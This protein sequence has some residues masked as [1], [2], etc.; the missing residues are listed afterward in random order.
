MVVRK[1]RAGELDANR[2]DADVH[3]QETNQDKASQVKSHFSV[4]QSVSQSR[5]GNLA[6]PRS[7]HLLL[8]GRLVLYRYFRLVL[9]V[10]VSLVMSG[11]S[12]STG[13]EIETALCILESSPYTLRAR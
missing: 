12:V 6:P 13:A 11:L 5:R 10:S 4:S 2:G 3:S 8:K 7:P 9:R 1:R